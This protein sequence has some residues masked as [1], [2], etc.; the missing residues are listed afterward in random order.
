MLQS[1]QGRMKMVDMRNN[2]ANR[3]NKTRVETLTKHMT[4]GGLCG[5]STLSRLPADSSNQLKVLLTDS[6][7]GS[8]EY[9]YPGTIQFLCPSCRR[10]CPALE[11]LI[12]HLQGGF[13]KK[14]TCCAVDLLHKGVMHV[15]HLEPCLRRSSNSSPAGAI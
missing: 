15:N 1:D 12:A 5:R 9:Q 2:I 11:Q 8:V 10:T 6:G 4:C 7:L 13:K 3:P 14:R